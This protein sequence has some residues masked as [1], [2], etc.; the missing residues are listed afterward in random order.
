ILAAVFYWWHRLSLAGPSGPRLAHKQI[1]FVGDAYLPA[2]SPDGKS[3]AYLIRY[4][5]SEQK[6][7]LQDISGGRSLE[8]L[9]E[10]RLWEVKWSPDGSE[11]VLSGFQDPGKT[12]GTLVVS[13]LGG[14][15]RRIGE[16][17]HSCCLPDGL[18]IANTA[19][20][21]EFGIWLV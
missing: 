1:T 3:V 20:Y 18:Q 8:L 14:T 7:M 6:L 13:R 15:P 10:K 17:A 12:R 2:I 9:H 16:G 11:L 5:G 21:P 4:A 19:E